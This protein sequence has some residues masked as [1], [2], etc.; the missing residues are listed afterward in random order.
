MV[1]LLSTYSGKKGLKAFIYGSG[2]TMAQAACDSFDLNSTIV[3]SHL[4]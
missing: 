1:A 2:S 4:G 3:A